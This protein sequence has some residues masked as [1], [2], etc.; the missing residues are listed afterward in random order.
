MK[1]YKQFNF[2]AAHSLPDWPGIHGHSYMAE[3]WF[4][5]PALDGYVVPE[6]VLTEQLEGVRR[7]LDHSNLN[8]LMPLPTSENIARYIWQALSGC[9]QLFSVRVMRGSVGF[10]VEY[11]REDASFDAFVLQNGV[12]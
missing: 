3:V 10:G 8:D 2:D 11:T 5:G 7:R 12:N 1:A 9:E 4:E 6:K